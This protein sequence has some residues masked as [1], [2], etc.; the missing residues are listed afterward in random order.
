[1]NATGA[2]LALLAGAV[3]LTV[4]AQ[5]TVAAKAQAPEAAPVIRLR[6]VDQATVRLVGVSGSAVAAYEGRS[7]HGR[8][9]VSPS[10]RLGTGVVVDPRGLVVTARHVVEGVDFLAAIFPG[11]DQAVATRVLHIDLEHDLA[12]L[13]VKR[14]APR[15]VPI[16]QQ[17]P[18]LMLSQRISASGYPLELRERYPA[19]VSGELSRPRND[20]LVQIAMSVNPGNSGGPAVDEQGRL[21]GIVTMR[22]DPGRGVQGV[23]FIEPL[24]RVRAVMVAAEA[25]G[26]PALTAP[27]REREALFAQLVAD[28]LRTSDEQPVY[29]ATAL[30]ALRAGGREARTGE[31]QMLVASHAWNMHIGLLEARRVRALTDLEGDDRERAQELRDLAVR[32][33]TRAKESAPYVGLRYPLVRAL[34]LPTVRSWVPDR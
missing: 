20:G 33:A 1:M 30:D 6:P 18:E 21:V 10:S 27:W 2:V 31:Q 24:A 28:F 13:R 29:E 5:L 15:T 7:G 14:D 8:V 11:E 22:G 4:A 19:A 23:A 17:D 25:D 34:T 3:G 16:P 9:I 26:G 12:V 32:L